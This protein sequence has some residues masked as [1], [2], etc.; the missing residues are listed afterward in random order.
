MCVAVM[1]GA[2]GSS[3]H[4]RV[5]K[6]GTGSGQAPRRMQ[7]LHRRLPCARHVLQSPCRSR[8]EGGGGSQRRRRLAASAPV[9]GWW[10]ALV[11]W[12]C[13][14]HSPVV[15]PL[16]ASLLLLLEEAEAEAA[17]TMTPVWRSAWCPPSTVQVMAEAGRLRKEE[18]EADKANKAAGAKKR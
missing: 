18:L 3:T 13:T 2:R 12:C 1:E 4:A 7:R 14:P 10:S 5:E 6:R 11:G 17:R 15:A 16:A 8:A 9:V